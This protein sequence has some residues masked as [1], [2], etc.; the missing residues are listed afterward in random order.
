MQLGPM[1]RTPF[2][3]ARSASRRSN[4]AP[5]SRPVS[6]KRPVNNW[7]ARAPLAAQSS[8]S[9]STAEAGMQQMT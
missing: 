8:T 5:S 2:A 1:I 3:R 6:E 7:R 4:S 9:S